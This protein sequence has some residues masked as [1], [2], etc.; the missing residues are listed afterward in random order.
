MESAKGRCQGCLQAGRQY[1]VGRGLQRAALAGA[2]R[3]YG[4]FEAERPNELWI[5][6]V[7]VGPF[8]PYPR[9]AGSQRAYLFL[10]VD[11]FSRLLLHGRWFP[12]QTARAGQATLRAAIQ[13]RGLPEKVYLDNGAP[14]A[15]AAIER[16][17][18]VSAS[19]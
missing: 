5:G 18:A 12:E 9:V 6:D 16:T 19:G 2:T 10:L 1:L 8:V 11:D 14:F 4:R 17:C 13:R 15:N 3:V 7:L